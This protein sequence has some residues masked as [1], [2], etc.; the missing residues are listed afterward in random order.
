MFTTYVM[1][2]KTL[3]S[4]KVFTVIGLL[5]S[6][7]FCF[8]EFIPKA[9]MYL[10]ESFIAEERLQVNKQDTIITMT[11]KANMKTPTIMTMTLTVMTMTLT[12]MTMTLTEKPVTQN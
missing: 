10:R 7:K 12:V 3:T 2:G 5:F 4:T 8:S 11:T 1:T 9:V 6:A